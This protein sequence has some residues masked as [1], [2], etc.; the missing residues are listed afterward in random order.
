MAAMVSSKHASHAVVVGGSMAGLLAARVLTDHFAKV[1]LI[2][3]DRFP[4]SVE[5]RRGVPQGPHAHGL[6]A[7]G[8][9]IMSR[10]FP[11]LAATLIEGGSVMVDL[12]AEMR[13]HHF[14]GYKV[15]FQ[16][17]LVG[18]SQ[19]RPFLEWHVRR[20]VLA[21]E[22]LEC[23]LECD[24]R[25]L[26]ASSDHTRIT[27]VKIQRRSTRGDERLDAHLV[28]DAMGRGS[29]SPKWIEWLGYPKPEETVI[30]IGVG[31]AS[32]I[33]RRRPGDLQ[34]DKLLIAFPTPPRETRMGALF[35]IEGDRW[36]L[37][38]G[39][40]VGDHPPADEEGFLEFARSLPAPDIYDFI[41]RAEP[42][43]GI[44]PYKFPSNL[45]RRYED[46]V[47][48]P[49]GYI[50]LGD[51]LCSLN[52]IYAQGMTVS[53]LEAAMLDQCLREQWRR[54]GD[55]IGFPRRF[56][57]RVAKVVDTVVI[58]LKQGTNYTASA[59]VTVLDQGGSPVSG[60]Q[61]DGSWT[62]NSLDIG[63][64]SGITGSDGVST[65]DSSKE[66]PSGGDTFR[67]TVTNVILDG[68]TYE[69][70]SNVEN[71]DFVDVP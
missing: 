5:N 22:N 32:R 66:K 26:V 67:F 10:L 59:T 51:A 49:E 71:S 9:K 20:R 11:D 44:V 33:Y 37:T 25:E 35:P 2:E 63:T 47:R 4:D 18:L 61:V 16:S 6:L 52:P 43:T 31:Y 50:V 7:E 55:L 54:R 45:R 30:K 23:L 1:T 17:G 29:P 42:L 60:A 53:A 21:L 3:R 46:M 64:G 48:L 28:V 14:G 68:Y 65:I 15:Q 57:R 12:G 8:K 24:A 56:F 36:L 58:S 19:S 41:T 39:G 13:W 40:W 38:L 70:A 27:G 34:G 62:L 69:S